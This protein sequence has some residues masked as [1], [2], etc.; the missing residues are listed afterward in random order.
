MSPFKSFLILFLLIFFAATSS[1]ASEFATRNLKEKTYV[2]D[3]S[4]CRLGNQKIEIEIRGYD[5]YTTPQDAS[6]GE[7]TFGVLDKK[8]I[9]LPLGK[10]NIGRYRL[11]KGKDQHCSKSLSIKKE[12]NTLS[13][14]FLKDNR[15]FPDLLSVLHYDFRD[16]SSKAEE[17]RFPVKG[18]IVKDGMLLFS[19]W[20]GNIK[21]EMKKVTIKEKEFSASSREL[22][23][24]ISY[25]GKSFKIDPEKTYQDFEL[26]TFFKDQNDFNSFFQWDAIKAVF[27]QELFIVAVNVKRKEKC[28]SMKFLDK[29]WRCLRK[30]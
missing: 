20:N 7:K 9:L 26:K 10:D 24:W 19:S 27:N 30:E 15:P 11:L 12:D 2:R 17:T 13:L 25:D 28:I 14:F 8:Y 29:N 5:Q 3:N 16:S 18:A 22:L 21:S 1:F 6:Y 23:V 4:Y